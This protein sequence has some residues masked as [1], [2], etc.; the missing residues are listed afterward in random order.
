MSHDLRTPLNGILGMAQIIL[1]HKL[2]IEERDEYIR[3]IMRSGNHLLSIID[4]ILSL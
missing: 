3:D 4:D 2:K 1:K